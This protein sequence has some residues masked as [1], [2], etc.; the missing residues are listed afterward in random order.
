MILILILKEGFGQKEE[1]AMVKIVTPASFFQNHYLIIFR[2]MK[3]QCEDF[4]E[5]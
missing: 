1:K 4:L 5:G 3:H 2:S